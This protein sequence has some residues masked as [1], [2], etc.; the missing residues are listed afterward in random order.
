LSHVQPSWF[1]CYGLTTP[2][3]TGCCENEFTQNLIDVIMATPAPC[4]LFL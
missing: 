2:K 3:P 1:S 4:T